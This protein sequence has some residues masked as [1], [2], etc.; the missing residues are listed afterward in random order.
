V[1]FRPVILTAVTTVLGLIPI[2]I[3]M[4]FDFSRDTIF[5]FGA[6]SASF[7]KSM[8]LAIMYGLG[9]TTFLTL[10]MLPTLYSLIE[11][12]RE[13]IQGLLNRKK[14]FIETSNEIKPAS[15]LI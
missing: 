1:R 11:G 14:Y 7:W 13:R 8:A 5:V 2:A 10:F 9:V 12:G 3:G 15:Q 6:E 4:D